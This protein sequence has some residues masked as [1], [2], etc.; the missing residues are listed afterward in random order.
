MEDFVS[1]TQAKLA[2]NEFHDM[3]ARVNATVTQLN[4]SVDAHRNNSTFWDPYWFKTKLQTNSLWN[5]SDVRLLNN[6]SNGQDTETNFCGIMA[7]A[8]PGG[9]F[10]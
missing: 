6:Q 10:N 7:S 9:Q 4:H 8:A 3:S 2:I 5:D 1:C